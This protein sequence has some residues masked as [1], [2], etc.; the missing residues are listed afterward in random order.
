[1]PILLWSG[2]SLTSCAAAG[3]RAATLPRYAQILVRNQFLYRKVQIREFRVV[4]RISLFI[5][6][7]LVALVCGATGFSSL[8]QAASGCSPYDVA[9]ATTP[10]PPQRTWALKRLEEQGQMVAQS[11]GVDA[12]LVGDSMGERWP[13]D[14]FSSLFPGERVANIGLGSD[15]TQGLLWRLHNVD[16]SSLNPRQVVLFL[17]TN[18]IQTTAPCGVQAGL[19]KVI[20]VMKENWSN[21][22]VVY[23]MPVLPRGSNF[24]Y[25]SDKID[26]LNQL[27]LSVSI[28]GINVVAIPSAV[29]IACREG[30]SPIWEVLRKFFPLPA[31]C[32][33][34]NDDHLHLSDE[35]YKFLTEKVRPH[36]ISQQ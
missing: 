30:E 11:G 8:A 13:A 31:S 20:E 2:P 35:G 9:L 15:T 25:L 29:D 19:Q 28:N 14:L 4:R 10:V 26:E 23:I 6:S 7:Y 24:E 3:D 22:E 21:L 18:N 27:F 5:L 16:Y 32:H 12:V 36:L 33:N 34:Y 17:G 1:M